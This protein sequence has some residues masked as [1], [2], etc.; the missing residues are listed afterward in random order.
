MPN[1]PVL[2]FCFFLAVAAVAVAQPR[3]SADLD[4]GWFE[5][6]IRPVLATQCYLCHSA[7]SAQPQAGLRLDTRDALRRGGNSGPILIPGRPEASLLMKALRHSGDQPGMPPQGALPAETIENFAV[8]IRAGAP[9]PRTGPDAEKTAEHT[10]PAG[11]D[12]RFWSFRPLADDRP[13]M[14]PN[15]DWSRNEIDRFI[16]AHLQ[17]K[18]LSPSPDAGKRT[19]IRRAYY[20]LTG[21]PPTWREVQDF[22]SDDSPGAYENL[23]DRLLA[24]P[25]Y[26]ERW[27][28]HWMDVSR[29][30][31]TRDRGSRFAFAYTYRDWVIQALNQD[32]PYDMFIRKQLAADRMEAGDPA[33]LAA[34]GF[35]TLGR[36][37][38]KGEHD[39]IDDRIDVVTRGLLGLTV[40]C[41]RCHDHK[42]DPI[43][44]RDYYS[45]YGIFRNSR[46]PVEYPLLANHE[47]GGS[48]ARLYHKGMRR[49]LQ[50]LDDFVTTRHEE[51]VDE[52]RSPGWLARYL[53]AATKASEMSNTEIEKLS[54]ERDY[55]LFVLRRWRDDLNRARDE[56]DAVFVLWHAFSKLDERDGSFPSQA[57]ALTE[58]L[59]TVANPLL[60][61]RFRKQPPASM[62]DVARVYGEMLAERNCAE[63]YPQSADEALRMTLRARSAPTAIPLADFEKIRGPGGDANIV[64][65]LRTAIRKWQ[66]EIAYRGLQP[67]AMSIEN[68]KNP[69]P[70]RV[71]I[72]GNPNNRGIEVPRQFLAV[73]SGRDRKPFREGSGR[74]ELANA[75]AAADN[76]LTARVIV[77]RVW[78]WHFGQG[79]VAT[80]SDFG[81]RGERPSH[82]ALLDNLARGFI[83]EGWSLKK[84]HRRIML[85]STYRQAS[86][87]RAKAAAVDPENRLLWRAN[88]QRL[89]FESLR[90]SMLAAAGRLDRSAGGLP[91]ALTAR[92]SVPRRTVYAY[93]ERGL[94][95]DVLRTFDFAN[96]D[97]HT[98]ERFQTTVP[99]QALYLMNSSFVVEQARHLAARVA[100]RA[101]D[102][103]Q[104][105]R[106]RIGRLYRMAFSR[107]AGKDEITWGLDYL[108]GEEA[109]GR[110]ESSAT[111]ALEPRWLH[112]MGRYDA[113]TSRVIDF[114]TFRYFDQSQWQPAPIVPRPGLGGIRLS[115]K[116]G[117]VADDPSWAVIRRWRAVSDGVATVGG[118]LSCKIDKRGWGDGVR[119]RV[120][121]SRSGLLV[122]KI[123]KDDEQELAVSD[124]EV[125]AGDTI[126]FAVDALDDFENDDFTWDPVVTL[127]D[128][129]GGK[130]SWQA[131]DGFQEPQERPLGVWGRYA[132]VLLQ[133]HEFAFV[134]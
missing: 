85:S 132:Q 67:R 20:D 117:T 56:R 34:L 3:P 93:F 115:A 107:E 18:G 96:P 13:P 116:A 32:M 111:V 17:E 23:I 89:D 105:D 60:V 72:R 39:M 55:N 122:E 134:D 76:P 92:P 61:A 4:P 95:P 119:A 101:E 103:A 8:W 110:G 6:K 10:D 106:E 2:R 21:L 83:K 82:P 53:L 52:F 77:N 113:G 14:A 129:R 121:H 131:S 114:K 57:A 35:I 48:L 99:Q 16:L 47:T 5:E 104:P 9:D 41:A 54:L 75:I 11:E 45:L 30:A 15:D 79:I 112:G 108:R 127:R 29:Y 109:A 118:K 124:I 12:E 128:K 74:L 51:L 90:D 94:L 7:A 43:P 91:Y 78:K 70:A 65:G 102:A 49:R 73:L 24:S 50:A 63:P 87:E 64:R 86:G 26:G 71:F 126:D 88:R 120:V 80:T 46:E 58:S 27:G 123:V 22:V 66:D 38:P 40:T 130:Q 59:A 44:T 37:V 25:H 84:L 62:S 36:N 98:A 42:Y 100:A 33:D 68:E 19:L 31:D 125:R 81:M 97:A 133:S 28:R 69:E 1:C